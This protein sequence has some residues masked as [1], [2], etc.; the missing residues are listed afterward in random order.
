MRQARREIWQTFADE[1]NGVHEQIREWRVA[2]PAAQVALRAQVEKA[3]SFDRPRALQDVLREASMLLRSS[4]VHVT[5]VRRS[6][7]LGGDRRFRSA[8]ARRRD[9][10][11]DA[12]GEFLPEREQLGSHVDQLGPWCGR[13]RFR[14]DRGAARKHGADHRSGAGVRLSLARP[15]DARSTRADHFP[16]GPTWLEGAPHLRLDQRTGRAHG[17]PATAAAREAFQEHYLRGQFYQTA[18]L[19]LPASSLWI[20]SDFAA[21]S[22]VDWNAQPPRY[23]FGEG[24]L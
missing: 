7:S 16:R 22:I 23:R 12:R 11:G 10:G 2:P 17:V 24:L 15:D 21:G 9:G 3:F 13:R 5:H 18:Q 14:A 6:R 19:G 8:A 4:I 20:L 1:V